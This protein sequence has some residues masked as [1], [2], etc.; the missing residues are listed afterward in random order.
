MRSIENYSDPLAW[1]KKNAI[2]FSTLKSADHKAIL[3]FSFLWSYFEATF[4]HAKASPT[5]IVEEARKLKL[6]DEARCCVADTLAYFQE[7][8]VSNGNFTHYFGDLRFPD[9]KFREKK[10]IGMV[11]SVLRAE[12]TDNSDVLAS[13]L[14]IVYRLRNN[15]FYG[16]KWAYGIQEQTSNF[17]K[18]TRLLLCVLF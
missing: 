14:L 7:R 12:N 1:L 6:S 18:A 3:N 16:E 17:L 8:Y 9:R 15:L 10:C 11:K 5:R 13:L 2:G 4:L